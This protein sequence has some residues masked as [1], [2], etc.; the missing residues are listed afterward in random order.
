MC[1]VKHVIGLTEEDKARII[2]IIRGGRGVPPSRTFWRGVAPENLRFDTL[3]AYNQLTVQKAIGAKLGLEQPYYICHDGLS[4]ATCRIAGQEYLNFSCYDYL[5]LNGDPRILE[6]IT[7]ACQKYGFSASASRLTAGERPPHRELEERI[8]KLYGTEDS[9]VFVSGHATNVSTV[10]TLF[11]YED[12][13]FSDA[14][15]HNSLVLGA[16]L[17]GAKRFVFPNNDFEFLGALLDQ[18]R[19]A[20]QRAL[21]VTEGLFGMD[22]VICNLPKLLEL[23]KKYSTFLM[24][25]EAHSMGNL[26]EHG[27]GVREYFNLQP[28]DVDIWMGTLS[29]TFCG[30]GGYIAGSK[31]LTE[32]LRYHA[33]GFVYSVGMP[34]MLA[35]ASAKA[36][37]L[38]LAEPWRVKKLHENSQY[39]LNKAKEA[40][41]DTGC[42]AGYAVIPVMVGDSLTAVSLAHHLKE[43]GI[44]TLPIIY[45]GVEEGC[46]RL[47][48]FVSATHSLEQIDQAV[49]KTAE[50]LPRAREEAQA[51]AE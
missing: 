42:A 36:I 9:L 1:A 16:T 51:F 11:G 25:D 28:E 4:Q 15:S 8:A 35:A 14:A 34:P 37:D 20:Y 38:M 33:P 26:G 29:K 19:F 10:A 48:F 7:E 44:L 24:V 31:V 30:C 23:K 13:I 43:N 32:I 12:A 17:S 40:G 18:H 22:G 5:G 50:L 39:L 2:Q 21:I 46:A 27:L 41:L 45:P 49:A 47:R 3:P 6:A